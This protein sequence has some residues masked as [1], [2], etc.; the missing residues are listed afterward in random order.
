MHGVHREP[1]FGNVRAFFDVPDFA[2]RLGRLLS[3]SDAVGHVEQR[4]HQAAV[5]DAADQQNVVAPPFG[6]AD[7]KRLRLCRRGD[8]QLPNECRGGTR[9]VAEAR[10]DDRAAASISQLR[11][12][13]IGDSFGPQGSLELG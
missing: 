11:A 10:D 1:A 13:T 12:F 7:E 4:V 6:V 8:S 5:I 3:P 9:A 2:Q